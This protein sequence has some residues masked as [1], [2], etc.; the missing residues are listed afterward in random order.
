MSSK[1]VRK[2]DLHDGRSVWTRSPIPR[3]RSWRKASDVDVAVIGAG[4]TGAI[5]ALWLA[6]NGHEI[7]V[8]DRARPASGS[9]LASTAMIQFEIDIPLTKLARRTGARSAVRA[10]HRSW[11]AVQDLGR[12]IERHGID[13]QWV[14]RRALY[15]AGNDTGWR[16]LKAEAAARRRAGLPSIFLTKSDVAEQFGIEA[17][18]ATVERH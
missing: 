6:E 4:I 7:A 17:T 8:I 3:V 9:T 10:Y 1:G 15:L 16:G 18:G 11:R 5:V 13:A 14:D 2:R 12:L